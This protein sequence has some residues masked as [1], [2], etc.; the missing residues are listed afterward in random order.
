M[1]PA[2]R[3]A[4]HSHAFT[5]AYT[6]TYEAPLHVQHVGSLLERNRVGQHLQSEGLVS[7]LS[8]GE[9]VVAYRPVHMCVSR[10]LHM[11]TYMYM[12]YVVL[13]YSFWSLDVRAYFSIGIR[14]PLFP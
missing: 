5:R 7:F 10:F 1:R 11:Y 8:G 13:T 6:F 2:Q 12:A 9:A 14:T 4:Y 3:V